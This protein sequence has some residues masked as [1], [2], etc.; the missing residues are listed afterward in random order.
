MNEKQLRGYIKRIL[1]EE[2]QDDEITDDQKRQQSKEKAKKRRKKVAD[3][4]IATS[5]GGGR[6]S[7]EV[8]EAG[9]LATENPEQL[10]KNLNI[11]KG[12]SDL[13]G[14]ANILS[15][16]FSG[17]NTM[18]KAYSGMAQTSNGDKTGI[19]VTM[20][21]LDARN[22]VQYL[23]HTLTGAQNAGLFSLGVPL[24]IHK[25]DS[26]EIVIYVSDR[27]GSWED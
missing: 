21:E 10:M 17:T 3:G 5:V 2:A 20:G 12:G 27:K 1:I 22:G 16:A 15:S 8:K 26:G 7:K 19:S 24:Q 13:Q 6:W 25:L 23:N 14:V 18:S 9:A 11:S 4:E